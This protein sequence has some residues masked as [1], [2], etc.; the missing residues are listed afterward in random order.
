MSALLNY[1]SIEGLVTMRG[2]DAA[3][4]HT[5]KSNDYAREAI[6][7]SLLAIARAERVIQLRDTRR[8]HV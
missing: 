4:A 2:F 8:A 5:Q 1:G 6:F 3:L 7:D